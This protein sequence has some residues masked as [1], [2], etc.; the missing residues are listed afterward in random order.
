MMLCPKCE[1]PL[2]EGQH[3]KFQGLAVFHLDGVPQEFHAIDI[4]EESN[5]E[6]LFC[7]QEE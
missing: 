2:K 1:R 3:V 6:H 7:G 4:Y 5:I